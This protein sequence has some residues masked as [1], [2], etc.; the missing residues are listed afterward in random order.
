MERVAVTGK[1][2]RKGR[3]KREEGREGCMKSLVRK[4]EGTK[5]DR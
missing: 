3:R 2:W 5:V 1:G 4:R